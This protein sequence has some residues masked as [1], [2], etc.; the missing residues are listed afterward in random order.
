MLEE[1]EGTMEIRHIQKSDD[2]WKISRIYEKSWKF[3]YQGIVPQDYL[4]SISAGHW[5]D[6][7]DREGVNSIIVVENDELIGTSSY[8]RS[9]SPEFSDFGEIISIYLLPQYIGRGYGRQLLDAAVR[10]LTELGF[11]DIFLW[12][13]AENQRARKF[14]EKNGFVQTEHCMEHVIGGKKLLE[15]QYYRAVGKQRGE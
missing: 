12:A 11:Q 15:V 14:Y 13:L 3:A 2:R 5:A 6:C 1:N 4:D 9:R 10:E 8:C 7:L